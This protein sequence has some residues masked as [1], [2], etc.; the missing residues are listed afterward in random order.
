MAPFEVSVFYD[1]CSPEQIHTLLPHSLAMFIL[2]NWML[3]TVRVG[4]AK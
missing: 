2:H 1:F 4:Y 3:H